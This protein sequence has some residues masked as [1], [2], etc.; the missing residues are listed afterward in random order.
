MYDDVTCEAPLLDFPSDISL[1]SALRHLAS[2]FARLTYCVVL[3]TPWCQPVLKI[4]PALGHPQL[5]HRF[6]FWQ[7][8]QDFLCM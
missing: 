3:K 7:S 1:A 6:T 5:T 8:H 4:L 2:S